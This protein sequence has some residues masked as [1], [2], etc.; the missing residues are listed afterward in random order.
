[1]NAN[2]PL[3]PAVADPQQPLL[4]RTL[5]RAFL[6]SVPDCVYFKDRESRFIAV[7]ASKAHRH[8]MKNSDLVGL[9]DFDVFSEEHA[10]WARVDEEN[11]MST[12]IPMLGKLEKLDW[13]DGR[14]TWTEVTKLP[15]RDETGEI[16][17]TFGISHDVS[18][19]Q[20]MRTDLE[21]ARRELVETSRKAGMAEV[22]TGVLHNVGNV[23]TSLNVS[24]N[25]IAASLHQS[26]A[27]SLSRLAA[28]LEQHEH[29]LGTF[30]TEDPK[31]RRVTEFLETLAQHAIEEREQLLK[32]LGSLQ[33]SID[34]VKEIV[35][36]QQAYATMVGVVETLDP[37]E[38]M[39]DALRMNAAAL[40]RHQVNVMREYHPVPR[41][42]A[43]KAKVLQILVNL[44]RNAK[45][46]CD[47]SGMPDKTLVLRLEPADGFVRLVISD[48]GIGIAPQNLPR[49]FQHGFTTRKEGHGFGLH[50][51][52]NAATEM[53]GVLTVSSSGRGQGATFTLH[54]PTASN[55]SA[56]THDT[57]PK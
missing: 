46:A 39:E 7:S 54:L 19:E 14:T 13:P 6:D 28:L 55:E 31:G 53:K 3:H 21:K 24:A 35:S 26:K 15:L 10:Q 45:Y 32:E 36:M 42:V 57:G 47:E 8:G 51:A 37:V 18:T 29:D 52:A 56:S 23:L 2:F 33:E 9:S 5:V 22:A 16:I 49:L 40:V 48:N 34:H 12:G 44:I 11:I 50:S 4:D 20:Q 41:V 43:E 38:M 30:V 17:G 25:M 27:E 1:M